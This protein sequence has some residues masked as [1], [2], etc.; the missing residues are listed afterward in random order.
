MEKLELLTEYRKKNHL[1]RDRLAEISGV[2]KST[3]VALELGKTNIYEAK[4]TT[5]VKL[6]SAMKIRAKRLYKNKE[7]WK[8][9]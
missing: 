6:A 4:I 3:I 9:I 5:V 1:T 8:K 2:A 7:I